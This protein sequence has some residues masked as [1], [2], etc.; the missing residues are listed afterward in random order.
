MRADTL[1]PGD[2]IDGFRIVAGGPGGGMSALY[3]VQDAA[4]NACLMKIPQLGCGSHPACY[5]GFE[6]E[7][8]ILERLS[9]PHVPA[10]RASG[11][12]AVGPYLVIEQIAGT[13][14]AQRAAAAPLAAAEV[15]TLGA[16]LAA[17]LHD[18]HRQ[19]VVH[20]DLKPSHVILRDDGSAVLID[21]GLSYHGGQPDLVAAEAA[22]PLGSPA[23][24]A[25]EQILGRRGDPRSDIFQVGAILY[26]LA[27]GQLPYG[28]PHNRF[29]LRW[30]LHV[31]P[32][33][34]R[35]LR[36]ELP[37]WLQEIILR[38][39]AGPPGE[40]Y[41]TAAHL[42]H[43]LAHPEQ[44][45]IT[46]RGRRLNRGGWRRM[47]ARGFAA[48]DTTGAPGSPADHL[49]Q[50]PHVLVAVDTEHGNAAL[51]AALRSAVRHFVGGRAHWRITCVSVLE[52]SLLTAQDEAAELARTFHTQRLVE[53]HHWAQALDLAHERVRCQVL[54]GADAASRLVE[55]ARTSHADHLI[56]GARG[57]S[58]LRRLLGS[59]SARVVAEAAC[60]VT[61]V[62]G[63]RPEDG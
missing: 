47:L 48:I 28:T 5:A 14:L 57:N 35:R 4:G 43:D 41:A 37:E 1:Q 16:A 7:R 31:D 30:R 61:V 11:E 19:D 25:P 53:L 49:A 34:P 54:E 46:E 8:V 45:R 62:R 29:G 44:L 12:C 38:C 52:S 56:M 39:L 50:V 20:H 2:L 27:T 60:S 22:G 55:Y 40:R 17:A 3:R 9:G 26:A 63:L 58:R 21:F 59:V 15:A 6:T 32:Q 36:P 18:L 24:L 51:D 23:Y 13:A 33:A 10:L 42:A